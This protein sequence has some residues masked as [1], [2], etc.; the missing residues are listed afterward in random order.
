MRNELAVDLRRRRF[1]RIPVDRG[2][3]EDGA[4]QIVDGA[5]FIGHA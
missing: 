5:T 1:R 2:P 3:V 4:G